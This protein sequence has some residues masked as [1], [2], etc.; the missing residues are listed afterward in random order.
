VV[1]SRSFDGR[2]PATAGVP[3]GWQ[4]RF[5]RPTTIP[6]EYTQFLNKHGLQGAR[7]G[8]TRVGLNGF[9][10]FVPTPP[11]VLEQFEAAI[12]AMANAGA[13]IIDLDAAGFTF[14]S[15]DGE[16]LV[17]CFEFRNDLK[18]YFATASVPMEYKTFHRCHPF[19]NNHAKAEMP[20]FNQ[21]IWDLL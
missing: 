10:P 15:A 4:G 19:N 11:A 16:F 21:D 2:D 3:L 14:P 5:T 12:E 17:L 9:D 13:T 18:A 7:L 20:F 6:I 8:V 1:Q